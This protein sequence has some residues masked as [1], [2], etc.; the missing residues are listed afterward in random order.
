MVWRDN[1]TKMNK[2][3]KSKLLKILLVIILFCIAF[4]IRFYKVDTAP[5]GI[6]IDEASYGYNAYSILKTGKDEFGIMLPLV[7]KAFGDQK[8]PLYT[9]LIVPFIKFFDLSL[10]AVRFP[11][12][13]AG[14]FLPIV[15]FYLLLELRF[16]KR[17]SF[18]GGIITATSPWTILLGRF[19]YESNIGLLFFSLGILFAFMSLRKKD[20]II[21]ILGG[22]CFGLTMYSYVAYRFVTPMVILSFFLIKSTSNTFLIKTKLIITMAFILVIVPLTLILFAKES[23]VRLT[24][25]SLNYSNGLKM[26]VDENRTYCSQKLP[27]I[28]CYGTSNKAL[29]MIR[30]Y[31]YRYIDTFSPSYLFLSGDNT[32]KS[33]NVDNFGLFYVWLLPFYVLG[34][35]IIMS[36]IHNKR[37]TTID[38]FV[39]I[40]LFISVT[41]SLMAGSP[42][43]L[44]LTALFPFILVVIAS[45]LSLF[46]E[47]LKNVKMKN[48]GFIALYI[49][50]FF[51]VLFFL[52]LFLTVHIQK[53]ELAYRT[54]VPKLMK[55]LGGYGVNKQIYIKSITEGIIY[56]SFVN[57]VNPISYQQHVVRNDPDSIGFI[58]SSNLSNIHIVGEDFNMFICNQIKKNMNVLYVSNENVKEIPNEVKKIIYTE[59][60]V[61]TP[62]IIYD[63]SKI[64]EEHL[65]C[66]T[67]K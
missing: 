53:Y 59:N 20:P 1:D 66:E 14:S 10:L 21:S 33:F 56:Y 19:G 34:I 24:Q 28:L 5:S 43:I 3:L 65:Q 48:M 37:F 44:R 16:T 36:R 39:I 32:N 54:Y 13:L 8:L 64:K 42:H 57:K 7:F 46:E 63:Y 52:I 35:L 60:G 4:T 51:S 41:P 11:S 27:G 15:I 47:Y 31:L 45:G 6:L 38:A 9:Y 23:S 49:L 40:G 61:D 30:T 58:H 67:N 25:A 22:V 18:F 26:E 55:A 62:A 12:V 17:V 29:F 2:V 50:T